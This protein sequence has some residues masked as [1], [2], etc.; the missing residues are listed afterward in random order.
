MNVRHVFGSSE[1]FCLAKREEGK[2]K[3]YMISVIYFTFSAKC[4]IEERDKERKIFLKN[5][6]LFIYFN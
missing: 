6:Y 5:I 1:I 3:M 2:L 4:M